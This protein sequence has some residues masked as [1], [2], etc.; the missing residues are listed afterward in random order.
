MEIFIITS[1]FY[2][3]LGC[4]YTIRSGFLKSNKPLIERIE[5][6]VPPF[7][8]ITYIFVA[9]AFTQMAWDAPSV[10]LFVAGI[11]FCLSVTKM[12]I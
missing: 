8:M 2:I 1:Q 6:L 4:L 10:V 5:G 12:I 7:L 9:F 3:V 11:Y